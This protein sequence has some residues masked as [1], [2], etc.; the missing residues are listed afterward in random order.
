MSKKGTNLL[1]D[2]IMPK[3]YGLGA[4]IVIVGAM[5]KIMHWPG[6]G[7]MLVVG[8][9]TEAIIFAISAFQKPHKDPAWERVYPQ[10]AEDFDGDDD[11]PATATGAVQKLDDMLASANINQSVI[12]RLGQGLNSLSDNVSKMSDLSDATVASGEYTSAIKNA[13]SSLNRMNDSYSKTAEA[14]SG[15][16]NASVE[17]QGYHE[18]V[19]KIT[20]NLGALN[21]VYEME[22]KDADNHL[23]AM[24]KFYANLSA[25][26]ENMA[27]ASKDT[28][29]FKDELGKLSKNLTSLNNVYGNMLSA[30]RG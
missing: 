11:E 5:F 30:M 3:V 19:Q 24:N 12:S 29:Q 6:A 21:A 18:Q 1:E 20:K 8:L 2:V 23:R 28:Q 14:M 7:P 26:M 9:T 16:A 13:T 4:A 10:L 22:L 17:A 25:A 27:D 15:M